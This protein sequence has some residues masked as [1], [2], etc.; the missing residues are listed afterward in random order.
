VPA[1]WHKEILWALRDGVR[2]FGAGSMGALRAAELAPYGMH[3]IG[4]VY[5]A[6]RSG[7]LMP[8]E[9]PFED[10]DE[11]AVVHGPAESGFLPASEAMVNIRVTLLA[12]Q[13]ANVVDRHTLQAFISI[14]KAIFFPDRTYERILLEA[15]SAGID[16]RQIEV[17]KAWLPT[18]RIDQKRCD[19]L[20]MVETIRSFLGDAHEAGKPDFEFEHTVLWQQAVEEWERVS[21]H[22]PEDA[23]VLGELRLLGPLFLERWQK[24]FE[25]L[26]DP[27]GQARDEERTPAEDELEG[28]A[29]SRAAER[30]GAAL[31]RSV[32]ERHLLERLRGSGEYAQ[33]LKK[34]K[35]KQ[36]RLRR[37]ELPDG[38]ELSGIDRLRLENW[39]FNACLHMEI[40]D[41][42]PDYVSRLGYPDLPSFHTAIWTELLYR[43]ALDGDPAAMRGNVVT[44]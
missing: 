20:A 31:P 14:A 2:V 5:E 11:V 23:Q 9:E 38:S 34:A 19:A 21:P 30:A 15:E 41:D 7:V 25:A 17:L 43:D 6:Y 27:H 8:F 24:V 12:A 35:D 37:D 33:F 32:V 39:Y 1:V 36:A 42:L 16:S 29:Q 13:G 28:L 10:D 3:G 22:G 40:P 18:G 26:L 44:D 4:K